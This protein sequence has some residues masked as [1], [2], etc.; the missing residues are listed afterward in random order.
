MLHAVETADE[1]RRRQ[2]GAFLRS[3]RERLLPRDV[4]LPE[5]AR[6]RTPGLRREEVAL[7]ADV[8]GTWYTWLE[9]GRDVRPSPRVLASL[10]RALKLDPT[11]TGLLHVLADLAPPPGTVPAEEVVPPPALRL[12]ESLPHPA[13]VTGRRWDVLA[14]NRPAEL[15]LCDYGKRLGDARNI[16][17]LVFADAEHRERLV[18][19]EGMA[20]TAMRYFRLDSA[21]HIGDPAFDRLIDGLLRDSEAF[22]AWWPKQDVERKP[23]GPKQIR[24]PLAG[25]LSFEYLG[26][27]LDEPGEM[28]L[29]VYTPSAHDGSDARLAELLARPAPAG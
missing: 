20:R 21:R 19:W 28:K 10:A 22:R 14:W 1:R 16:L 9:Q 5:G 13:Y 11:E 27:S 25:T 6:R 8:G 23:S 18:D 17:S 2:L 3:R 7:I 4:G 12:L 26:L 29:V 24:H 15:A